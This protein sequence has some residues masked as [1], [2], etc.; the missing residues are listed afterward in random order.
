MMFR[1]ILALQWKW[2]R[3]VVVT[4]AVLGFAIPLLAVQ[5]ATDASGD[6]QTVSQLLA[7][8]QDV[9]VFFPLLAAAAGLALAVSAWRADHAGRHVYAVSLPV[10]R[11]QFVLYRYG[12]GV[13]LLLAPVV[14]V[15]IGSLV[16]T[17]GAQ[18]P[19]GLHAYPHLITLRF[20]LCGLVA[21][22]LFFAI[23]AG[24][25]RTAGIVL[26]VLVALVVLQVLFAA[27]KLDV[28]LLGWVADRLFLWPG[29][30]EIYTGRWSLIDV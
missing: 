11:W 9:G 28:N 27:F 26:G 17:A 10:P 30:L 3:L 4:A 14:G 7:A 23:S 15:W 22:S 5:G 8:A 6:P 12:A 20:L 29:P 1:A 25:S 13:L 21:F 24:T 18:L 19:L 2:A 16:A